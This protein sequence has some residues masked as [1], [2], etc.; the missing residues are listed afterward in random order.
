MPFRVIKGTFH[1]V[2]Y[3]PDGD[4]I[5]FK[6]ENEQLWALL[7]GPPVS[8]NARRHAQLRLE[9]I[10][11]L[12]THYL[13]VHQP[14]GL[15]T[16]ALDFLLLNLGITEVVWNDLRTTVVGANDGTPGYII[17]RAVEANR[18]PVSFVFTGEPPVADGAS[19]FLTAELVRESVNA[20]SLEAGLAYPTYY[21]GLFPDLRNALTAATAVA[22][23]QG[24][25]IW[26]VDRTNRGFAV[27]NLQAITDEHIIMPKLFRRIAEFLE[28]G[29]SISGFKEFLERKE[30]A[31]TIIST[32]HFTHF[33]TIIEVKRKEV[34]MAEPP[35]NI[36]FQG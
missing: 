11:T 1:V 8:L 16:R 27:P 7:S 17:S 31:I 13:N 30:E 6:A 35:E 5:R 21:T 20:R 33:D 36:I 4:S 26:A 32:T 25:E 15:A 29:G 2:G 12:E 23:K 10:D 18:R 28:A 3:S 9:A 22:R 24:Y 14:L 34:T 19:I